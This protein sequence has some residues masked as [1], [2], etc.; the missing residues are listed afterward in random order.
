MSAYPASLSF[1]FS[2]WQIQPQDMLPESWPPSLAERTKAVILYTFYTVTG[3][4]ADALFAILRILRILA[5]K[6]PAKD[7]LVRHEGDGI[8]CLTR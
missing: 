2:H 3:L 4:S 8:A 6:R 7:Y 5:V 1:N